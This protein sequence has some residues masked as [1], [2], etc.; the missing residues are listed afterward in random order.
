MRLAI[1]FAT[2]SVIIW[3]CGSENSTAPPYLAL[4]KVH[5]SNDTLAVNDTLQASVTGLDQFGQPFLV[6][7]ATW[8][9]AQ[10]SIATVNDAGRVVGASA[11]SVRITAT[12]AG[13][14]GS[15]GLVVAGTLHTLPITTDEVWSLTESPHFVRGQ[16]PVGSPSGVVLTLEAGITIKLTWESGFDVGSGGPGR[17]V[18]DGT[19]NRITLSPIGGVGMYWGGLTFQGPGQSELRNVGMWGCG[20]LDYRTHRPCVIL[21]DGGGAPP[22]LLVDNVSIQDAN[23]GAVLLE[24][25]ARFAAGSSNLS[26]GGIRGLVATMPIEAAASF[27]SGGLF[28][29]N[30]DNT[31][32][33]IGDS[34]SESITFPSI[35]SAGWF[36]ARSLVIGG[37]AAPVATFPIGSRLVFDHNSGLTVGRSSPGGIHLTGTVE[38]PSVIESQDNYAFPGVRLLAYALPSSFRQTT[39]RAC[40][41][42]LYVSGGGAT[43]PEVLV[44]NVVFQQAD[45]AAIMMIQGGRF[46]AGSRLIRVT[47]TTGVPMYVSPGAIHTI[48]P[49]VYTGNQYDAIRLWDTEVHES[50]TWPN[51]GIP[52][53]T[54]VELVVEGQAN[55]ILTLEPGVELRTLQTGRIRVGVLAPGGLRAL[56]TA[57]APV[58]LIGEV[59]PPS[60]GF[61]RGVYI[62]AQA[63]PTTLI[64]YATIEDAGGFDGV[65]GAGIHIEQDLGEIV[66]HTV[67]RRSAECGIVRVSGTTWTT[68]FTAPHLANQFENVSGPAQCGP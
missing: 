5:L 51:L 38:R 7:S 3:G 53:V 18:A 10:P 15:T 16:L 60:P 27:P 46:A 23:T 6:H 31:I 56:G 58:R 35:G 13:V 28:S 26:V 12:S 45:G 30:T 63:D 20:G 39:F 59:T 65:I 25:G 43:Q 29:G 44:D 8:Q 47:G 49:G 37:P 34:I 41:W 40:F 21:K 9:S 48:P 61:W 52:Y 1:G 57:A 54:G 33:L 66:K 64:D 4:I 36:F 68:D 22:T 14:S 11:G 62:G 50:E 2:M 19:A 17:L 24:G 67:I 55:P 32:H 42:C